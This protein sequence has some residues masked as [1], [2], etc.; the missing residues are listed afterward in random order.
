MTDLAG[1]SPPSAGPTVPLGICS[2]EIGD[3]VFERHG[4]ANIVQPI[5][6]PMLI[7]SIDLEGIAGLIRTGQALGVQ[8]DGDLGARTFAQLPAQGRAML[9]RKL[10]RQHAILDTIVVVDVAKTWRDHR[11]DA[12]GG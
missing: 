10:D 9:T 8:V 2:G 12:V 11:A 4:Q 6:Q 1:N 7:E 3:L 5:E